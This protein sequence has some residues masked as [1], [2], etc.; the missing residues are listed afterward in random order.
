MAFR[1]ISSR[2]V[3]VSPDNIL[4]SRSLVELNR[5]QST[6]DCSHIAHS[7]LFTLTF[8]HSQHLRGSH[9]AVV[10]ICKKRNNTT[11]TFWCRRM[12]ILL[13]SAFHVVH[14]HGLKGYK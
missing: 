11:S 9:Q 4:H 3:N 13:K 10:L 6:F 7:Q 12:E 14:W 8:A 2:I 1:G 5:L